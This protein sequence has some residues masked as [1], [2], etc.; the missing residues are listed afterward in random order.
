VCTRAR[1][2]ACLKR[3]LN[4]LAPEL[5]PQTVGQADALHLVTVELLNRAAQE[6]IGEPIEIDEPT[7]RDALDPEIFVRTR[8]TVGSVSPAEF[9]R[10]L[11]VARTGLAIM[12]CGSPSQEHVVSLCDGQG[13]KIGQRKFAHGG[14]GLGDMIAWLLKASGGEPREIHVAIETPHGPIVE[15]LLEPTGSRL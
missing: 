8:M 12:G 4:A 13:K 15:A 11:E 9:N 14:T 3:P 1:P 10:M 5:I 7:I 2:P 6:T